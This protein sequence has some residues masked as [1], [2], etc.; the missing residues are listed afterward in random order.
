MRHARASLTVLLAAAL[1][2]APPEEGTAIPAAHARIRAALD[3]G[4]YDEAARLAQ[5]WL[6][7]AE[8]VDPRSGEVVAALGGLVEAWLGAGRATEAETQ[9]AARRATALAESHPD[10]EAAT[11]GTGL[12]LLGLVLLDAGEWTEA[13]RTL[14]RALALRRETLAADAPEIAQSLEDLAQARLIA[15]HYAEARDL[16]AQAAALRA[17]RRDTAPVALA[18][19]LELEAQAWREE[20]EY[21]RAR[22]LLERARDLREAADPA[23]PELARTWNALGDLEWFAGRVAEADALFRRALDLARAT[24]GERHPFTATCLANCALTR[25]VLGA[26]REALELQQRALD[27]AVA[28]RGA[29]HPEAIDRLHELANLH[30]ERGDYAAARRLFEEV[31]RRLEARYRGESPEAAV[32]AYN[33]AV[34][35][36]LTNDLDGALRH[37]E[38][39]R[40]LWTRWLTPDHAYVALAWDS[41][42]QI[43]SSRCDDEPARTAFEQALRIREQRLGGE[44]PDLAWSLAMLA[45]VALRQ[46]R[47]EEADERSRHAVR[48]LRHAGR[49]GDVAF[50]QVAGLRAEIEVALGRPAQAQRDFE[51]TAVSSER[52]LGAEHPRLADVRRGLA[53][54]LLAQGRRGRAL[55]EALR[56]AGVRRANLLLAL[57]QFDERRALGFAALRPEARDLALSALVAGKGRGPDA[58]RTFDAVVRTRA[59]VQDELARRRADVL[60]L[61]KD[62]PQVAVA[63]RALREAGQRLANL[64]VRQAVAPSRERLPLLAEARAEKERLEEKLAAQ[65]A[66]FREERARR[67][68]GLAEVRRALPADA[69]LVSF[70]RYTHS[71]VGRSQPPP[72]PAYMAFVLRGTRDPVAVRLGDAAAI[73]ADVARWR[74]AV[75]GPASDLGASRHTAREAGTRLY[76]RVWRPLVRHFAGARRVLLVPDGALSFVSFAALPSSPARL[77]IDDW[78]LHHLSAERDLPDLATPPGRRGSGLLALGVSMPARPPG[79]SSATPPEDMRPLLSPSFDRLPETRREVRA[80]ARLWPAATAGPARALVDAEASEAA[81]RAEAAGRRV[82]HFATHGFFVE[83]ETLAPGSRCASAPPPL[84]G[85]LSGLVLAGGSGR[86]DPTADSD[87]GILTDLEVAGLDLD[88]VEW[89]VLS[90][91]ETGLGRVRPGEGAL[92]LRRAFAIAGA[93]TVIMSLW[94]TRDEASRRFMQAL[95]RSHLEDGRGTADAL[96][97]AAL[98]LRADPEYSDVRDWAAFVASGD[99]R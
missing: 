51:E 8:A 93:R 5:A 81:L 68:A 85:A 29:D 14:E 57:P 47:T 37:T 78:A 69:A 54:A 26:P 94:K 61:L 19:G 62:A 18:R 79:A 60:A 45:R 28:A 98:E 15:R 23:H 27:G 2:L 76:R 44:H 58:A 82:L 42:G 36:E 38:R 89:V 46:G 80:L 90:G 41:L 50:V 83:D 7:Q 49:D 65:S 73:D 70:V 95:Y 56:A 52:L 99:W 91:C 43:H 67:D 30:V 9:A 87:D 59:L 10:A 63:R 34:L 22:P 35:D 33:R 55:D 24:L 40:D 75:A 3:R 88:G 64:V 6:A 16:L 32:L 25:R 66:D 72:A 11:P 53:V 20:A 86:G 17:A 77:V 74:H 13:A 1:A 84:E 21:A 4:G 31:E 12:R 92:G 39:A 71:A 97:A 96:R 48:L